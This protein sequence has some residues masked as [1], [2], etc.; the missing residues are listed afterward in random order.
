MYNTDKS[1]EPGENMKSEAPIVVPKNAS[2]LIPM[3]PVS[4]DTIRYI[5]NMKASPDLLDFDNKFGHSSASKIS[6]LLWLCSTIYSNCGYRIRIPSIL[7]F[8][9]NDDPHP[10]G[11]IDH[12][13]A[14][15][16]AKDMQQL[17]IDMNFFPMRIDFNGDLF[18]KE[19]ICQMLDRDQEDYEFPKPQLDEQKL[20]RRVFHRDYRKRVLSY[21]MLEMSDD[22]KFSVGVYSFLRKSTM[23]KSVMLSRATKEPIEA[24]RSYRYGIIPDEND[25]NGE[26]NFDENL[27]SSLMIKYQECGGEKIN[28]T[29]MEVYE[30]KQI[31]KPSI[32]LLGFKPSSIISDQNH[33]KSPYF[34]YPNDVR[35]KN[36]STIFRAL[37]QK[38][39]EMDKIALCSFTLRLKSFP[40]LVALVPQ[41]QTSGTD[42][43]IIRYDGFRLEF[44]PFA[45]DV[46]N[47]S[48]LFE[49]E[50]TDIAD[51]VLETMSKLIK[52]LRVNYHPSMFKNPIIQNIYS[53]I[54]SIEFN[55]DP[56]E[57][58]DITLPETL[59]QDARIAPFL[60]DLSEYFAELST[61]PKQKRKATEAA[62]NR[63]KK[64]TFNN[65]DGTDQEELI[66]KMCQEGDTKSLT[67]PVLKTYLTSKH[68]SGISKM[69]KG[70]MIEKI[71]EL[72]K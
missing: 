33:I 45:G 38:C 18:F 40:R 12:Q 70:V 61:E 4:A 57:V 32:K 48:E 53:N 62:G 47:L 13:Q 67:V 6:D 64:Q 69:N 42:G 3:K 14:F 54:E 19:F 37:W 44:I 60:K 24:K 52:K 30:M 39:L 50:I 36:S 20:M 41:K 27:P 17:Q 49:R 1:P 11:S 58:I 9:D 63:E 29:P 65:S 23:P 22:I 71:V 8:T 31:Q 28:F 25:E 16:K 5:K 2:I 46:R 15:Q 7:W 59:A 34:L 72:A 56:E 10:A 51:V 26:I 35:V 68:V 21:L 43:E 55:E 66:L